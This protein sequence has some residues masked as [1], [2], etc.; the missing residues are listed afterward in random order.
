VRTELCLDVVPA[1]AVAD[2][3][4][5]S[6]VWLTPSLGC[7]WPVTVRPIGGHLPVRAGVLVRSPAVRTGA[8]PMAEPLG[9]DLHVSPPTATEPLAIDTHANTDADAEIVWQGMPAMGLEQWLCWQAC[10]AVLSVPAPAA[11]AAPVRLRLPPMLPGELHLQQGGALRAHG[12]LVPLAGG[13]A[14]RIRS[15]PGAIPALGSAAPL[16]SAEPPNAR[17][18]DAA[19]PQTPWT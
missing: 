2:L 10:P 17:A 5:G 8:L 1:A 18:C 12:D 13:Y 7:E 4:E 3:A 16:F 15:G 11:S 9:L 19:H 6:L 14:L